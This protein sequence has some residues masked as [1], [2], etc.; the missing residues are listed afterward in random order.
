MRN[1]ILIGI[2]LIST[3][4]LVSSITAQ[5][6]G[7]PEEL[8]EEKLNELKSRAETKWD[9]LAKEW[10]T[11]LLKNKVISSIDAFLKK[12]SLVFQILFGEPYSPSLTLLLIVILW[13]FLLF[14]FGGILSN[15][16]TL[17]PV[18]S[19]LIALGMVVIMAQIKILKQII[20]FFGW[21][22]F[23]K[24]TAAWRWAIAGIIILSC[25]LIYFLTSKFGKE[26]KKK[27]EKEEEKTAKTILKKGAEVGEKLSEAVAG[28]E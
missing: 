22:I 12:G 28:E 25:I 5:E 24:E 18:A 16:S 15:Y 17:S 14:W 23:S 3:I 11:L 2:I 19:W 7:L 26:W 10:Q 27:K 20:T 1:Y 8:S 6:E 21:L 4:L 13:I 9:Y